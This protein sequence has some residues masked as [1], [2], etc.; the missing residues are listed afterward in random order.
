MKTLCIR[1]FSIATLGVSLF[2]AEAG[3]A[4][5]YTPEHGALVK[6]EPQVRK[7]SP[8]A[9]AKRKPGKSSKP[10]IK[11]KSLAHGSGALACMKAAICGEARGESKSGQIFVGQVILTRLARGY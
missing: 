5:G 4:V 8:Q 9:T 11:K 10:T 1:I 3:L 7:P 2:T 6:A